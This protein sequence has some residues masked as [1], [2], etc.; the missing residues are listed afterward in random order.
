M[1]TKLV[2]FDMDGLIFD[3]ERLFMEKKNGVLAAYGYPATREDYV[4]TIG[5]GGESLKAKLMELYGED[6]PAEE[7]TAKTR[8]LVNRH[9]EEVGPGVKPGIVPLLCWLADRAIPCCVASSSSSDLVMRYLKLAGLEN[10]FSFV[11]GGEQ[12]KRS[13]PDPEMFLQ[14]CRLGGVQPNEALV[15]EDSENG[16]RGAL[17]AEIP[18]ICIPDLLYPRQELADQ[19]LAVVE[20]ADQVIPL[21]QDNEN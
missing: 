2:I 11:L 19:T 16:I 5:L 10:A 18:V 6:Y 9:M 17:A 7:I 21:L 3:T 13:K 8:A 12:V 15:L 20:T 14:A 4:Q 1:D